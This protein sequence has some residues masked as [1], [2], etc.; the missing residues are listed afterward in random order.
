MSKWQAVKARKMTAA[1]IEKVNKLVADEL[2]QMDLREPRETVGITQNEMAE[3][4]KKAQPEISRRERR[5]DFHLSTLQQY[6]SALGGE[7][8][9]VAHIGLAECALDKGWNTQETSNHHAPLGCK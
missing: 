4:L 6:V 3:R 8:E 1:Q 2:Q 9:S 5:D 7:L